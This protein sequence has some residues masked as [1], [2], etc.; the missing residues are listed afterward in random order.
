MFL[1]DNIVTAPLR[2]VVWLA[3]KIHTAAL[4]EQQQEVETITHQLTELYHL[5]DA[6]QISEAEFDEQEKQLLDQLEHYE[7][8][9]K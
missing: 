3:E 4:D 7:R 9:E 2:G 6:G 8:S 5:L 1:I